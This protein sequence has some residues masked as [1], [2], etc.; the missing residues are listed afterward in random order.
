MDFLLELSCEELP[1]SAAREIND[2]LPSALIQ[3]W[4]SYNLTHTPKLDIYITPRRIAICVYELP[5]QTQEEYKKVQGPPCKIAFDENGQP[6]QAAQKFASGLGLTL[7]QLKRECTDKG[8]YLYAEKKIGGEDIAHVLTQIFESLLLQIPFGKSMRWGDENIKFSRPVRSIMA[9]LFDPNKTNQV[10]ALHFGNLTAV[11]FTRGHRFFSKAPFSPQSIE[12]YIKQLY[13]RRVVLNPKDRQESIK[14]QAR[15]LATQLGGQLFADPQTTTTACEQDVKHYF[16]GLLNEI[17]QL[18]EWPCAVLG[19]FSEHALSLPQE[20]ILSAMR[21]HQR[22]FAITQKDGQLM[23]YFITIA[24]QE[25]ANQEHLK[26]GNERVLRA[27]LSDASYFYTHDQKYPLEDKT[28]ALKQVTF[29]KKLGTSYDKMERVLKLAFILAKQ[30]EIIDKTCQEQ[31][32]QHYLGIKTPHTIQ[33]KL[34]RAIALCKADLTS[35]MVLE[36]PELQGIMG[37]YYARMQQEDQ[38]VVLAIREHYRPQNAEDSLPSG[39]LGVFISLADKIDTLVGIIASGQNPSGSSDP[40]GLRRAAL[41]ILKIIESTHMRVSLE[42]IV[43]SALSLVSHIDGFNFKKSQ[44]TIMHFLTERFLNLHLPDTP[45]LKADVTRAVVAAQ[46]DDPVE[47]TIRIKAA[48]TFAKSQHYAPLLAVFKRVHNIL[49]K[50]QI[51]TKEIDVSLLIHPSE[52]HLFDIAKKLQTQRQQLQKENYTN[53][54]VYALL[55]GMCKLHEPLELFFNSVMVMD[56]DESI[57]HNRL[58]LLTIIA[59]LPTGLIV[60]N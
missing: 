35:L 36:F 59:S 55:S 26:R 19:H 42:Q 47:T 6:T 49:S 2:F 9:I 31:L 11:G 8:E 17:T 32:I 41:G 23:P 56:K 10:L 24:D 21:Q 13:E 22:Y 50:A 25:M 14:T 46:F 4:A 30:Q 43:Q 33:D 53:E 45:G 54:E 20:V 44:L 12:D 1:E 38:D 15:Q 28:R 5:K 3:K 7:Q 48:E 16:T 34:G 18:T 52:V 39:T 37:Q 60:L 40:F 51:Q 27:R 57:K 29:H 58:A